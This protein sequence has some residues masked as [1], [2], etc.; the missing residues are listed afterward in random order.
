V[1]S[2]IKDMHCHGVAIKTVV[3]M[4]SAEGIMIH[5]D[6]NLQWWSHYNQQ[7]LGKIT[8]PWNGL[9]EKMSEDF[10]KGSTKGF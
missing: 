1:Q 4:A 3:V 8:S 6:S 10:C 5:H 2:Y 7:R 9:C